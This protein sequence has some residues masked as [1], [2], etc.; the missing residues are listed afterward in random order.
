M[1][2]KSRK[3]YL[4]RVVVDLLI[5]Q[6]RGQKVILDSD[7][8][9]VYGVTTKRLNEQVKR[10]RERFPKDFMFRL[11]SQEMREMH[12]QEMG[13]TSRK[14]EALNLRSQIATS[15]L[16]YGGRRYSPYVFTEHGALM[17]ANVLNSPSAIQMSVLVVRAFV[18]MKKML[19]SPESLAEELAALKKELRGRLDTHEV[20]IND[21]L[22]RIMMILD[23]PLLSPAPPKREI[24]FHVRD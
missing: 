4:R 19:V 21:I 1:L 14:S 11:R 23:P 22:K 17:A 10:N 8:A 13:K 9:Q 24:G 18:R 6:I 7:L 15:S 2:K 12:S 3:S 16:G 5:H 20:A